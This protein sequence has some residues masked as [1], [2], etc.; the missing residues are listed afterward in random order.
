MVNLILFIGVVVV[1]GH[2]ARKFIFSLKRD[3]FKPVERKRINGKDFPCDK[4]VFDPI[5][6]YDKTSLKKDKDSFGSFY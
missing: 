4:Y 6:F 2:F 3:G 1:S 5:G